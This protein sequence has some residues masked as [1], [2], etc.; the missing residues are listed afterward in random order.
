MM[1]ER[2][3]VSDYN[4]EIFHRRYF[5]KLMKWEDSPAVGSDAPDFPLWHLDKS[6]TS[7]SQ[8]WG[9]NKFLIVE[10]GSFT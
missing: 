9:E 10:F 6:E 8:L 1:S 5:S 2:L 4:Y 7:L 3:S